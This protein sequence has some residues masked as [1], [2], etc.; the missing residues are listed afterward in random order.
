MSKFVDPSPDALLFPAADGV[1]HLAQSTFGKHWE[2]ARKAA[3][4]EDMPW[5]AL[6]HHGATKAAK[7]GATLKELQQRLGHST[8]AAAMR[9]QHA[10]GRD[11]ELARRMS[12]LADT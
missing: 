2:P 11:T 7:A 6:R 9:Y 4:R 1:S 5:H 8:V 10:A 3:G 12:E